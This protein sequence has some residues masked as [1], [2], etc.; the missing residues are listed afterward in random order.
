MMEMLQFLWVLAYQPVTTIVS[1]STEAN[2]FTIELQSRVDVHRAI[3]YSPT[4]YVAWLLVVKAYQ[5]EIPSSMIHMTLVNFWASLLNLPVE[6][7]GEGI[8]EMIANSIGTFISKELPQDFGN[9]RPFIRCFFQMDLNE[10]FDPIFDLILGEHDF[11]E[12]VFEARDL[13]NP[14]FIA[15]PNLVTPAIPP[16]FSMNVSDDDL[17]SAFIIP[18]MCIA[19]M[20]SS[21]SSK[22]LWEEGMEFAANKFQR[23]DMPNE[24]SD[25]S[26]GSYNYLHGPPPEQNMIWTPAAPME[27]PNS[28]VFTENQM[29]LISLDGMSQMVPLSNCM[30]IT[31]DPLLEINPNVNKLKS[32]MTQTEGSESLRSKTEKEIGNI[33]NPFQMQNPVSTMEGRVKLKLNKEKILEIL[34]EEDLTRFGGDLNKAPIMG[35]RQNQKEIFVPPLI[36]SA[37][38]NIV[39][40]PEHESPSNT[41]PNIQAQYQADENSGMPIS[42]TNKPAEDNGDG[43]D[44]THKGGANNGDTQAKGDD[45]DKIG[46]DRNCCKFDGYVRC[47]IGTLGCTQFNTITGILSE[48]HNRW[49]DVTSISG[50]GLLNRIVITR[51]LLFASHYSVLFRCALRQ[52]TTNKKNGNRVYKILKKLNFSNSEIVSPKGSIGTADDLA[53]AWNDNIKL[54]ILR[55]NDN[56]IDALVHE[57]ATN[58]QWMLSCLYGNP[59]K[60]QK[61]Q[62]WEPFRELAKDVDIPWMVIG[63]LHF[64]LNSEEKRGGKDDYPEKCA[65]T[66]WHIWK[67]RCQNT[68]EGIAL[69]P[70]TTTMLIK[71]QI[72]AQANSRTQL[73]LLRNPT[74]TQRNAMQLCLPD[75]TCYISVHSTVNQEAGSSTTI[76]VITNGKNVITDTAGITTTSA[77]RNTTQS[78][79]GSSSYLALF[80]NEV[81][82]KRKKK[83]FVAAYNDAP[84]SKGTGD[85]TKKGSGGAIV[86]ASGMTAMVALLGS[87][88]IFV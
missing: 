21:N 19:S 34:R 52:F 86:Y 53:L 78:M 74:V 48:D 50:R 87:I 82:F 33:G 23:W 41:I 60:N 10:R 67:S 85:H 20:S 51:L 45:A 88:L 31:T 46:E 5:F 80:L 25:V 76:I 75:E 26:N 81:L 32:A 30:A 72:Q 79:G 24:E 38:F 3:I 70:N 73:N 37:P 56:Q 43:K 49:K 14:Q 15:P 40:W 71:Q 66:C 39:P 62:S 7:W 77:T 8:P 22:R 44:L 35:L 4:K 54:D 61:T 84:G 1:G 64:I 18:Q 68:F 9:A 63:D 16:G 58:H 11:F 6:F 42:D 17:R 28:T 36:I 57:K 29:V 2:K 55:A 69:S 27:V 47:E 59:N 65:T 83:V 13:I 12:R